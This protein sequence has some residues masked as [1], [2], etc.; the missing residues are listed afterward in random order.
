M[1]QTMVETVIGTILVDSSDGA[2][3]GRAK[4]VWGP[5]NDRLVVILPN[6]ERE[7]VASGGGVNSISEAVERARDIYEAQ[8]VW[9][10]ILNDTVVE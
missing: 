10:L 8:R 9:G 7:H 6:G 2:P 4:I 3:A 5:T 1:S